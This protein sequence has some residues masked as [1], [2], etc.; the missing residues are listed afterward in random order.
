MD[1]QSVWRVCSRLSFPLGF[2]L[3]FLA[4]LLLAAEVLAAP[5]VTTPDSPFTPGSPTAAT[6]TSYSPLIGDN[7]ALSQGGAPLPTATI[8]NLF[9]ATNTASVENGDYDILFGDNNV[10]P[11]TV[12]FTTPMPVTLI[13]LAVYLDSDDGDLDGPRSVGTITFYADGAEVLSAAPVNESVGVNNGQNIFMFSGLV[14]AST[15]SVTFP[16]NPNMMEDNGDTGV[17]PRVYEL[18]GIPS[19]EPACMGLVALAGLGLFSR[20]RRSLCRSESGIPARRVRA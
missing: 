16:N 6:V 11:N 1:K 18:D 8:Y 19:P 17:G 13:G 20:P 12:D 5:E 4:A 3:G 7:G 10:Q 15:F 9:G 2:P 14:T